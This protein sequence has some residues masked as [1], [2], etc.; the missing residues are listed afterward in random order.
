M[1]NIIKNKINISFFQ[2]A[3]NKV[4][5]FCGDFTHFAVCYF[6]VQACFYVGK[7][8]TVNRQRHIVPT[9]IVGLITCAIVKLHVKQRVGF[10][11]LLCGSFVIYGLPFLKIVKR[12]FLCCGY[13]LRVIPNQSSVDKLI[14]HLCGLG[15]R[16]PAVADEQ[17]CTIVK[18]DRY[19][20][21]PTPFAVTGGHF[22]FS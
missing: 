17:R 8:F 11:T 13:N 22:N 3:R 2:R 20:T 21:R 4:I 10:Q 14:L 12:G 15:L 7:D 9:Y 18:A 19:I 5:L 1:A 16:R 6:M